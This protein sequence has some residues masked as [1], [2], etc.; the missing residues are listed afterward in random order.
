MAGPVAVTL[1]ANAGVLVEHEGLG[2]L[3]DGMHREDGHAFSRVPEADLDR[4][5][6]GAAPFAALEY[7]LFTHEHPDHFTPRLVLEHI[8]RRPVRGVIL[9]GEAGGSPDLAL[10]L[11]NLLFQAV[12]HWPLALEPGR[13]RRIALADGLTVTGLGARH[14]GP[15]YQAVCNACFLVSLHGVNLLFTGDAD[16]VAAYYEP[17]RDV[18]LDAV[19]VNPL[20]YHAEV[21]QEIIDTIFRPRHVVVYHLPFERDDVLHFGRMVRRD[22]DKHGQPGVR[23]HVMQEAGQRL[24]LDAAE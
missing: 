8:R 11:R 24:R 17:L 2:L 12:P 16:H 9:P 20:F 5:R 3:V 13:T 21:G 18:A 10:L 7:L 22:V 1:V 23:T 15:Q 19:F 14:M 4:M 6:Q